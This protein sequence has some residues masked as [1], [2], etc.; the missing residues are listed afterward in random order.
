MLVRRHL[1][2]QIGMT[3]GRQCMVSYAV[4]VQP[5]L[6]ERSNDVVCSDQCCDDLQ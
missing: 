3:I 4:V 1:W 2:G 5:K 6:G